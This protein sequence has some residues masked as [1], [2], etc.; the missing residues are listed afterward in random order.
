MASGKKKQHSPVGPTNHFS[1]T[2]TAKQNPPFQQ[3]STDTVRYTKEMYFMRAFIRIF[4]FRGCIFTGKYLLNRV[5]LQQNVQNVWS[6]KC[7]LVGEFWCKK[8]TTDI[9]FLEM[10]IYFF[11]LVLR[12]VVVTVVVQA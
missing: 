12:P 5:F 7:I 11:L 4:V 3:G 2:S 6:I 8:K 10:S 9:S 1:K